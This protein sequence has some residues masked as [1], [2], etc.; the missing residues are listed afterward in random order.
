MIS[1]TRVMLLLRH[2]SATIKKM[3]PGH[4]YGRH[5]IEGIKIAMRVIQLVSQETRNNLR[6]KAML[7]YLRRK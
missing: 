7:K 1:E 2:E 5:I 3:C 4:P 6:S